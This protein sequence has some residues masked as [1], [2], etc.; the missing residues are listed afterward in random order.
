MQERTVWQAIWRTWQEDFSDLPD[1]EGATRLATRLVIA[2]LLGGLLG[3]EREMRGKDAGL[4]THMLLGLGAA[5]F[6]FIPQQGGMSDDGLARVIQGV[7]AGVGFL[8]GGA[9]LKLSEE[10]RIEGLTTAAG[11]WLTAAVGVAAGLGRV[12]TAVAGT[13]LA[14]LVLTSLARL[15]AALDARARRATQREDERRETPRS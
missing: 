8:G 14:L 1:V 15:S 11:I 13:L 6:V 3:W 12:A 10:R 5:L 4:R 9:I 2:A 7:V